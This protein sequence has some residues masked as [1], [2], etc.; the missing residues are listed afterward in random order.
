MKEQSPNMQKVPAGASI[1]VLPLKC[2]N[3]YVD[4]P[5][6]NGD[7]LRVVMNYFYLQLFWFFIGMVMLLGSSLA[8]FY[9]PYLV[10][11]VIDKMREKNMD[12]V[13]MVCLQGLVVVAFSALTAGIRGIVFN[14]LSEDI[15]HNL[16][17]DIF[18]FVINKDVAFFDENKTGEL[19]SRL[20]SD[21]TVIQD[22]LG[23]NISMLLRTLISIIATLVIL[24]LISWK[25]TLVLLAGVF[26]VVFIGVG[27]GRT[28]K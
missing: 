5:T 11:Q 12:E 27:I 14:T 19:L 16:R 23:T 8:T 7:P 9:I 17:Y 25:L 26:P 28:M 18:F 6:K 4:V 15:S 20:S 21:T 24:G 22:A 1:D 3:A 2:K 13:R 10:G